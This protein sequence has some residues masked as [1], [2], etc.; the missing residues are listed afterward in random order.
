MLFFLDDLYD[1]WYPIRIRG[2]AARKDV[3]RADPKK[4]RARKAQRNARKITR[5]RGKR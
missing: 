5:Q 4:A 3:K 2:V 1:R